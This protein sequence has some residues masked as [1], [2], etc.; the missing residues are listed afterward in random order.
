MDVRF[1]V[2]PFITTDWARRM[3]EV[4]QIAILIAAP[5]DENCE[6]TAT[7]AHLAAWAG[8]APGVHESAGCRTAVGFRHGNKWLTATLVEAAGTVGRSKSNYLSAQHARLMAR[9]GRSRAQVAVALSILVSADYRRA[10]PRSR[11]RL[12]ALARRRGPRPPAGLPAGA[13]RA[14]HDP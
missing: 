13:A 5:G 14:H 1:G 9:R 11:P 2:T 12:A 7:A 8:L 4:C 10:L 3:Q 6:D